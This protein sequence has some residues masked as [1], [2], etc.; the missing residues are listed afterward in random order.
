METSSLTSIFCGV[1]ILRC[2]GRASEDA[3]LLIRQINFVKLL[4]VNQSPVSS[5]HSPPRSD[6]L[7]PRH[8]RAGA[9]RNGE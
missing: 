5:L 8:G 7:S 1:R 2:E 9:R 4:E 3:L 6:P